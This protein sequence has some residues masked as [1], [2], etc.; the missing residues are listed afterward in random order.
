MLAFSS[1]FCTKGTQREGQASITDFLDAVVK[2]CIQSNNDWFRVYLIRKIGKE[3][4][5]EFVQSL[6]KVEGVHWVFPKE[7]L[8]KVLL[9]TSAHVQYFFFCVTKKSINIISDIIF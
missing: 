7:V 4:G 6:L 8:Q 2:L 9:S 1:M 3:H 5:V